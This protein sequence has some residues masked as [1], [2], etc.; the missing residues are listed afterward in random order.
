MKFNAFHYVNPS[1]EDTKKLLF[2]FE[3]KKW[4][5]LG[6]IALL[7]NGGGRLRIPNLNLSGLGNGK[8]GASNEITGR[9][10]SSVKESTGSLYYI[11]VPLVFLAFILML[12]MQYICSVFTFVFLEALDT[13]K[14]QVIKGFKRNQGLG[15]SFF[16]FK[17]LYGLA[18]LATIAIILSPIIIQMIQQGFTGF[19]ENFKLVSLVYIIPLLILLAIIMFV[20][21]IFYSLVFLFSVT[22]MYFRKLPIK[23]S[24]KQTFRQ[25]KGNGLEVFVFLI[26]RFV[27]AIVIGIIGMIALFALALPALVI[28]VP[29]G[30]LAY[31]IGH[32]LAWSIPIIVVLVLLGMAVFLLFLYVF[33]VCILPISVFSRYFTINNYKALM[34]H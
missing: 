11:L 2:P 16:L 25:M 10:T 18:A 28:L 29:F 19:F 12:I 22:H 31:I 15:T 8:E 17:I 34:K 1:I 30:I 21:S 20:F 23:T 6:F 7:G 9:I 27:I 5:K 3:F 33:S 13:R 26:A 24:I 32:A 4:L 14:V